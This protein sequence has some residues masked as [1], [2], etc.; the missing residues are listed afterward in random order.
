MCD[1]PHDFGVFVVVEV[2]AVGVEDTVSAQAKRL[3]DL[4][5][6]ANRSHG[7]RPFYE[8]LESNPLLAATPRIARLRSRKK[9]VKAKPHQSVHRVMHRAKRAALNVCARRWITKR[10]QVEKLS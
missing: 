8:P 2:V 4:E 5:I 9:S 6:E 7:A 10:Q 1:F 3:V